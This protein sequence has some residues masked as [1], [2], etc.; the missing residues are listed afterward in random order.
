MVRIEDFF[1]ERSQHRS[2]RGRD[3]EPLQRKYIVGQ[4]RSAHSD[5]EEC[6]QEAKGGP[7]VLPRHQS[8]E[9]HFPVHLRLLPRVD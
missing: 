4:G 2:L 3:E 5:R 8:R 7:A 6:R 1:A 9:M